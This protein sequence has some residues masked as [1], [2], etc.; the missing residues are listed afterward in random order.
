MSYDTKNHIRLYAI[1][2]LL[3]AIPIVAFEIAVL[4]FGFRLWPLTGTHLQCP[5][6]NDPPCR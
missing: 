6:F 4:F 5:P 3:F 1:I 2:A